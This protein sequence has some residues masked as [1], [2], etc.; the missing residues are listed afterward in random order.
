MTTYRSL[1]SSRK[2]FSQAL[3]QSWGTLTL[4]RLSTTFLSTTFLSTTFL[5]T[6]FI[7]TAFISTQ[8]EPAQASSYRSASG[9]TDLVLTETGANLASE[10]TPR[11]GFYFTKANGKSWMGNIKITR[12]DAG[13]GH[14]WYFGTFQDSTLGPGPRSTCRGDIKLTRTSAGG[15][16]NSLMQMAAQWTIT[17]GD[18]C[19]TIGQVMSLTLPESLPKPDRNG[20]YTAANSNTA[21]SETSGPYTWPAWFAISADGQLNCRTTPNGVVQSTYATGARIDI[22]TRGGGSAFD[23]STGSPWLRTTKGC[24]VRASSQFLSPVTIPF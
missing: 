3:S 20:N 8:A 10:S 17:G 13:M 16:G 22:A 18:N 11:T 19:P 7:S 5:S 21:M 2:P 14:A 15:R 9:S 12:Q 4:G 1:Q 23:T 6:A 24:L